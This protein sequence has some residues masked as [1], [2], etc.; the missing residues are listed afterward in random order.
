MWHWR[1]TGTD[2]TQKH[3]AQGVVEFYEKH[4]G[5]CDRRFDFNIVINFNIDSECE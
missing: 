5:I 3:Q 2:I 4:F 1:F